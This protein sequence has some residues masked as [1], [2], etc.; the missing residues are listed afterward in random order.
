MTSSS[1]S[2]STPSPAVS[3]PASRESQP[4][5]ASVKE[6][7]RSLDLHRSEEA[8][9]TLYPDQPFLI[10]HHLDGASTFSPE[11]LLVVANLLDSPSVMQV[12][13][14]EAAQHAEALERVQRGRGHV[15]LHRSHQENAKEQ[16]LQRCTAELANECRAILSGIRPTGLSI[17]VAAPGSVVPVHACGT[18]GLMLQ[19]AGRSAIS[20]WEPRRQDV[21][22]ERVAEQIA[23]GADRTPVDLRRGLHPDWEWRL[24]MGQGISL[25]RLAPHWIAIAEDNEAPAV[26]AQFHYHSSR[27]RRARRAH[28][29][30]ARLRRMGLRPRSLGVSP[31][32]DWCKNGL[33]ALRDL[34]GKH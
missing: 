16:L 21:L 4:L 27:S 20:V 22:S 5:V 6:P 3:M 17:L 1:V 10:R 34:V 29:F 24:D 23:L 7:Q 11:A 18:H 32:T 30:N 26:L 31:A 33:V 12:S 2:V 13:S 9:R 28:R 25:P 15:W 19:V 14:V 8:L